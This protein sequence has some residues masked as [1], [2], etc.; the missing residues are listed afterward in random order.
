MQTD[1]LSVIRLFATALSQ[2]IGRHVHAS[3]V[4]GR[5]QTMAQ[6]DHCC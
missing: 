1:V 6:P 3:S 4:T 5:A 2:S